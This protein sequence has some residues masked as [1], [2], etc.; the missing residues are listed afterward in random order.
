MN[1]KDIEEFIPVKSR[2]YLYYHHRIITSIPNTSDARRTK[3]QSNRACDLQYKQNISDMENG[4]KR[5]SKTWKLN[6][7]IFIYIHNLRYFVT[8]IC[9]FL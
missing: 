6:S 5:K 2:F 4:K 9:M 8:N 3:K 7:V 1:F